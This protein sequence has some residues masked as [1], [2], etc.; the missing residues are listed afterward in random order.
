MIIDAK[1]SKEMTK[2]HQFQ[3]ASYAF[4]LSYLIED[5]RN[6]EI[7]PLGGVWLPS[8]MNAPVTFRIDFQIS[9]IKEGLDIPIQQDISKRNKLRSCLR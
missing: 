8:D 1:S 5:I 7:D 6:L 3:V 9:K 2:S 4:F